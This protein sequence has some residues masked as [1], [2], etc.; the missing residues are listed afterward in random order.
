MLP[1]P[2]FSLHHIHPIL[3]N[4]TAALV[5]SSLICDLAGKVS[6]RSSL[7]HAAWWMIAFA[8]MLTPLTATA[9][10][11]WKKEVEAVTSP[12]ILHLHMWLG[13]GITLALVALASWR[14]AIHARAQS[15]SALYFTAALLLLA[16]LVYQGSL[17]G[18]MAFGF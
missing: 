10:L 6:K 12:T 5:P 3:V 11:L 13:I 1:M 15:P 14:G 2:S 18:L 8:A 7:A 9:G 17:G 16:A 4:F